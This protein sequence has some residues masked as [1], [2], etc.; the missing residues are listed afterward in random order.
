M[1]DDFEQLVTVFLAASFVPFFVVGGMCIHGFVV[2]QYW[3]WF[4]EPVF[5][6]SLNFLT[7]CGFMAMI[8]FIKMDMRV[9][10]V[11]KEIAPIKTIVFAYIF[12]PSLY[13]VIGFVI[14]SFV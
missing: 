4:G 1:K 5:N 9:P 7:I 10:K 13:Y 14:H 12:C 8:N 11:S 2:L 3:R 6:I